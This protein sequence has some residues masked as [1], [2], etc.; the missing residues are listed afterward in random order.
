[1]PL[2][3]FS[4]ELEGAAF[5]HDSLRDEHYFDYIN[6]SLAMNKVTKQ[7]I[8]AVS[9]IDQDKHQK[10]PRHGSKKWEA[11][12]RLENDLQLGNKYYHDNPWDKGHMVQR[13]NNTWGDTFQLARRAGNDTF[14]YTNA[15][16]QHENYNR[17][18][19]L[20]LET[21]FGE[22]TEDINNK[23]SI[24]TGPIHLDHDRYYSRK[25]HDI[26]RIPS[27]FFKIICYLDKQKQFQTRAFMIFQDDETLK[28]RSGRKSMNFKKYQVS[29]NEIEELTGLEFD[30]LMADS[31]PVFYNKEKVPD[32][33]QEEVLH[34]PERIPIT[35]DVDI[36]NELKSPRVTSEANTE[37]RNVALCAAMIN[38]SGR[39]EADKE[40]ISVVNLS[41]EIVDL[42]GW[43]ILDQ[44]E[45][46][47]NL[48]GTVGSGETRKF[49]MK[50]FDKPIRLTNS[51]GSIT[52]VA[53]KGVVMDHASWGRQDKVLEG[54][55]LKF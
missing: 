53:P 44:R 49:M 7:L 18:E 48:G 42:T 32:D 45:R 26:V 4:P 40:W 55:A 50:D 22:W 20:A 2:P 41:E 10:V 25:W 14:Y 47:I 27:A 8:V 12:T 11:D 30:P 9:N 46:E 31:N 15:S 52:L 38:P 5:K 43:K 1:M 6:F 24:F 37:Q 34:V 19:W 35:K 17:D 36:V 13:Y 3:K 39:S 28:N 21:E 54:L 23:L 29:V 16:F 51:Q 33:M